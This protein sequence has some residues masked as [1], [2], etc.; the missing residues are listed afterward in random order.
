MTSSLNAAAFEQRC[1]KKN[2]FMDMDI[3]GVRGQ[4]SIL[5]VIET[6]VEVVVKIKLN[7]RLR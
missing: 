7:W 3:D 6:E 1:P 2:I 5:T 4:Y